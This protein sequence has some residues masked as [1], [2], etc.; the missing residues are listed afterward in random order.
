MSFLIEAFFKKDNIIFELESLELEGSEKSELLKMADEIAEIRFLAAILERL[1]ESDK[2]L[3][4]DQMHG[5]T[6][7]IVA[8]FIREKIENIE[9]IL[10]EH[11]SA[12][13]ADIIADIKNLKEGK[14]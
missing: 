12:L 2:E 4:L 11:A 8:E 10:R 1:E 3:F 13:E 5:D 7:E 9:E 6:P 14:K